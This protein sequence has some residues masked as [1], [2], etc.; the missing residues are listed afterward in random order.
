[1]AATSDFAVYNDSDEKAKRCCPTAPAGPCA[2]DKSA[3]PDNYQD[4]DPTS[5]VQDHVHDV[6][7]PGRAERQG[8]HGTARFVFVVR[9]AIPRRNL[10]RRAGLGEWGQCLGRK[11][12]DLLL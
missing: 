8:S 12:V 3:Q 7:L 10:Q 5:I 2:A 9:R 1:M 11:G 6:A 4:V